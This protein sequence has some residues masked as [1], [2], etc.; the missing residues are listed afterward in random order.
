[1][2]QPLIHTVNNIS[3]VL[4][5]VIDDKRITETQ[6]AYWTI[7]VANNLRAK[8]EQK[9]SSGAFLTTFAEIPVMVSETT[10]PNLVRYR[11][12]FDLPNAIYDFNNDAAIEYISY[13]VDPELVKDLPP[14]THV[15]FTRTTPG[16]LENLYKNPYTKPDHKNPYF[17]RS[18][19]RIYLIGLECVDIPFLEIAL[20]MCIPPVTEIDPYAPFEFPAE[21]LPVLERQ[22]I[23]MGRFAL[24]IPKERVNDGDNSVAASQIP[25]NK[26]TSVND[27]SPDV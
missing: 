3:T 10:G 20:Y 17:Y 21:L 19:N 27:I 23:D 1:M 6:V 12:Y 9:R 11:K 5:Q 14:L 8:H 7:I 15:S 26:I 13:S 18:G 22:V 25:Q 24:M 16:A 2:Y 4:R